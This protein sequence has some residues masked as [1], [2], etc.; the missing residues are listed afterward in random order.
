[1]P[2]QTT[3]PPRPRARKKPASADKPNA[4]ERTALR[5]ISEQTTIPL[6]QLARFLECSPTETANLIEGLAAKR[7]AHSKVFRAGDTRWVWLTEKGSTLSGTG[8]AHRRIPPNHAYLNHFR[9][10]NEVRLHL[11]RLEPAGRWVCETRIHGR[12]PRGDRVPDAIFEVGGERHAIEVELSCKAK[13]SYRRILAENSARYDAVIYFASSE[14]ADTLRRLREREEWPKLIVRDM[15]NHKPAEKPPRGEALRNPAEGEAEI[16]HLISEQGAIRIDQLGRFLAREPEETQQLVERLCAAGFATR[17]RFLTGE[18][19]WVC[20][21]WIG[22]RLSGSPLTWFRPG[23]GA[24]DKW[25][26]LNE[27]RIY[28]AD[29]EPRARWIGKRSLVKERGR[30]ANLP[31]AELHLDS[32]RLALNIRLTPSKHD[33][34]IR[35]TDIQNAAYDAVVFFSPTRRV[36]QFMERLQE[37]HRWSKLVI[38]DAPQPGSL[39]VAPTPAEKL[40]DSVLSS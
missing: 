17:M 5:L 28:L 26:L 35:R 15:P 6:D 25:R 39:P 23:A 7:W 32:K 24:V 12:R 18:P 14:P 19:E 31:H 22:N 36:R 11:A 9:A 16:L 37:E 13:K 1:M 8:L 33:A 2:S 4:T 40:V 29:A 27:L 30:R 21:T 3:A 10:I 38:R 20:L 34:F